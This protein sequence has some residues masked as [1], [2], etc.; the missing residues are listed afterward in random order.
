LRI[1]DIETT[2]TNICTAATATVKSKC[3]NEQVS[4]NTETLASGMDD[5][6]FVSI[7]QTVE[8]N[9]SDDYATC[10]FYYKLLVKDGDNWIS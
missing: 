5:V 2:E 7:A 1:K 9:V 3:G 4:F 8:A 6:Q 10:G